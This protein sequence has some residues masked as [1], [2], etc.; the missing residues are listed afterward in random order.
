MRVRALWLAG[1]A[2][3]AALT[4]LP[5]WS[6]VKSGADTGLGLSGSEVPQLLKDIKAAPYL[7][8]VAPACLTVPAEIRDISELIG[9]D[10]DAEVAAQ[11]LDV[12]SKGA[13]LARGLVPYRGLVRFATGANKKD[14]ELRDAV[15]A[16][17]ARRGF[18][19]GVQLDVK[20]H[21]EAPAPASTDAKA[22][23]RGKAAHAG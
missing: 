3:A 21:A 23:K 5:A 18:L 15:D 12:V 1:F 10:L 17:I 7:P 8:P 9:P 2:G 13:S 22:R 19:R 20:C 4:A 16:A 11:S 6:Q 14:Q